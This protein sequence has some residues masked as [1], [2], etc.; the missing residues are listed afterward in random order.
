MDPG[1]RYGGEALFFIGIAMRL[2]P[3]LIRT[4]REVNQ[5]NLVAPAAIMTVDQQ[6]RVM[7]MIA[8]HHCPKCGT[9]IHADVVHGGLG[10]C[11]KCGWSS[12]TPPATDQK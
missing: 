7:S 5:D 10:P 11:R 2:I 8:E 4:S 12:Q 3:W 1:Y 6:A 9:M